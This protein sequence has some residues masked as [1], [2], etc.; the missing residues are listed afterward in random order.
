MASNRKSQRE[1]EIAVGLTPSP[2]PTPRKMKKSEKENEGS[3]DPKNLES[4]FDAAM[5]STL[6]DTWFTMADIFVN[7]IVPSNKRWNKTEVMRITEKEKIDPY[8]PDE[9]FGKEQG[10]ES[11]H[12][13][14][15][16][17]RRFNGTLKMLSIEEWFILISNIFDQVKSEYYKDKS[18]ELRVFSLRLAWS[19]PTKLFDKG[20]WNGE[21]LHTRNDTNAWAAA[22][23]YFGAPWKNRNR[24]FEP[25]GKP[26]EGPGESPSTITL[27]SKE[28]AWDVIQEKLINPSPIWD[29]P[30]VKIWGKKIAP[31][32]QKEIT[33]KHS[34]NFTLGPIAIGRTP[35]SILG[36][37]LWEKA[38]SKAFESESGIF[39]NNT[40][41]N[42]RIFALRL[43]MTNP[44]EIAE[45]SFWK[46]KDRN[47]KRSMTNAWIGAYRVL[48]A[49]WE[50]EAQKHIVT[51]SEKSANESKETKGVSFSSDKTKTIS[52][53]A[54]TGYFLSKP[55]LKTQK[56]PAT[57]FKKHRKDSIVRKNDVFFKIKLPQIM[58]ERAHE[59]TKEVVKNLQEMMNKLWDIDS[60]L[61][62]RAWNP[63]LSDTQV[64]KAR[65]TFPNKRESI[66]QYFPGIYYFANRVPYIRVL[67][68]FNKDTEH[69]TTELP[70][71][72]KKWLTSTSSGINKEKLQDRYICRAGWLLGSHPAVFNYGDMEDAIQSS[73]EGKDIIV[74]LKSEEVKISKVQ[75]GNWNQEPSA[76]QVPIKAV[77]VWCIFSQTS[78][79]RT[80]MKSLFS[81]KSK[82]KPLGKSLRFIPHILDNRYITTDRSAVLI[83][84]MKNKQKRFLQQTT[85]T[86][87]SGILGLDYVIPS[88]RVSLRQAIMAIRSKKEPEK[89]VFVSVDSWGD[90]VRFAFNT[91]IADE[92][93]RLIPA[94]PIFLEATL[95]PAVWTWFSDQA[96]WDCEDF[97]W[98]FEKG[99]V[100]KKGEFDDEDSMG[101][102]ESN[103]EDK[104]DIEFES[105]ANIFSLDLDH[106]GTNQYGDAGSVATGALFPAD[107]RTAESSSQPATVVTDNSSF[108]DNS[109]FSSITTSTNQMSPN[110]MAQQLM[111]SLRKMAPGE[112]QTLL[113]TSQDNEESKIEALQD[114]LKKVAF[115]EGLQVGE[116]TT[117]NEILSKRIPPKE[118]T[119]E[120]RNKGKGQDDEDTVMEDVSKPA[121]PNRAGGEH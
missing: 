6:V 91:N 117:E 62:V 110:Q 51:P 105:S 12:E 77:H 8:G 114:V 87:A 67:L 64:I 32:K 83:S 85:F 24:F 10:D 13:M 116:G 112:L 93:E 5:N 34:P 76:R 95:G 78:A 14:A 63:E 113:E 61:V 79:V 28:T 103:E 107:K 16:T 17:G 70:Y 9:V 33:A 102:I 104:L 121:A 111:A 44:M 115:S 18:R 19:D 38:F 101:S 56:E 46:T 25:K 4:K 26:N 94:L 92:A 97:E 57:I 21:V 58:A 71:E 3:K 30:V 11:I 108:T 84:K 31:M 99:I 89:N 50:R 86:S 65:H 1:E 29:L 120:N 69:F 72:F 37:D 48:G 43:A 35:D 45:K 53:D 60:S 39:K 54:K 68:G 36:A 74:E 40:G 15:L 23:R 73:I 22:Y 75:Q 81:S 2:N 90:Q 80:K 98:D 109:P 7:P 100:D 52:H 41:K 118:S 82:R 47:G 66:A 59:Q 42:L 27:A 55:L 106:F 20:T 119:G 49:G 88:L 96:K